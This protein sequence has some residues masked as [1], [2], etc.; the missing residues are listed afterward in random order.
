MSSVDHPPHYNAGGIECIDGLKAML[1][2]EEFIG[3]LKGN[4]VK[5]LWRAKH[6]GKESEDARK[7]GWYLARLNMELGD[8]GTVP[9]QTQGV[10][11]A[12]E[13]APAEVRGLRAFQEM[14]VTEN[15][16]RWRGEA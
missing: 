2:R 16:G 7:A 6:K 9:A 3:F 8:E 14:P 4:V 5:Y 10:V 12:A 1:S 11:Q 15:E 13:P